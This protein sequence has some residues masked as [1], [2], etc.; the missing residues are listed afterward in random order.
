MVM[1]VG[2]LLLGQGGKRRQRKVESRVY[3]GCILGVSRVYLGC[4]SGKSRPS[5]VPTNATYANQCQP[6]RITCC[7]EEHSGVSRVYLGC[8]SGVSPVALK[9][10]D[11][12]EAKHEGSR[13]VHHVGAVR[14]RAHEAEAVVHL[15][16]G[17]QLHFLA[18]PSTSQQ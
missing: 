17:D 8:I 15:A 11:T 12:P 18:K 2:H 16:T 7:T 1:P 13:C 9:S 3:L 6:M 4:V 14:E 5:S 10:L